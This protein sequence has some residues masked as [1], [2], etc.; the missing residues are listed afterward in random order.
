[1]GEQ[2]PIEVK[3]SGFLLDGP[4][5]IG[6]ISFTPG[7]DTSSLGLFDGDAQG[8]RFKVVAHIRLSGGA[9]TRS[10]SFV[11]G[12]KCFHGLVAEVIGNGHGI[13][14]YYR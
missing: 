8:H 4:I 9:D 5:K 13:V 11:P 1:M 14:T 7:M 2:F 6:S 3:Q 10:V 12:L